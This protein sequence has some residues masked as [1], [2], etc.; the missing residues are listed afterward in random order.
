MSIPPERRFS[1]SRPC[2]VCGGHDR[3]PRGNNE[4]CY[5]FLSKDGAWAH[6]TREEYAGGLEQ[7]PESGTYPHR[8]LGECRCGAR[9]D[10]GLSDAN[11][12]VV[13]RR[14]RKIV[15]TYDYRNASGNS[16]FQVVRF[17]P[18]GFAQRRPDGAGGYV[19]NLEG[20][21]RVLYRLP[22]LLATGPDALIFLPEGEKDVDRLAALGLVATT[23]PEG[24]GK[25]RDEY[26][27]AL[28]G[29]HVAILADN[30]EEGRKHA[31]K[32]AGALYGNAASVKVVALPGLP[33]EG[34]VSDWLDAG[35][36]LEELLRIVD[37]M[38]EWEPPSPAADTPDEFGEVGTL[39]SE[40][41][42]E[43]VEW[44]WEGRIPLAKLTVID[45]DPGTGKSALTIDLAAR[46][47]TGRDMPTPKE[48]NE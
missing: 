14:A 31:E 35:N 34:D 48:E 18:K 13:P 30:D 9:H 21:E 4:R 7:N 32:V 47:S 46:V 27:A 24:A 42:E 10:P 33:E 20:I 28:K 22:E 26:T 39:L 5:G 41:V 37:E 11:G 38:P 3:L 23:N 15:D 40:V 45:G 8:L 29:R 25:W 12:H 44:L 19:W 17:K 43:S 6:C 1:P 36:T 16:T 2:P